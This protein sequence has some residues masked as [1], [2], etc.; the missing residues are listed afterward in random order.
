MSWC[1]GVEKPDVRQILIFIGHASLHWVIFESF[2]PN[3]S[4][5][6]KKLR[7]RCDIGEWTG[8]ELGLFVTLFTN[9]GV[10][11]VRN[12]FEITSTSALL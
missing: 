9:T 4:V 12:C 6:A 5:H 1:D 10:S 7:I 3:L 2:S 8:T 11:L